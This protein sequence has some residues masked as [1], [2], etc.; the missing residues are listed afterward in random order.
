[1]KPATDP[2]LFD[3]PRKNGVLNR[4][5]PEDQPVHDWYRFVLSFPPHLVREYLEKFGV[6][7][8]SM[9]L[10]PFCG[11]GTT[12]VECKK[13]GIPVIGVEALPMP[14]F[15][16]SVKVDWSPDPEGLIH[17]AK[18]ISQKALDLLAKDGIEDEPTPKNGKASPYLRTLPPD[19]HRLLL[20]NSISPLPLHKTLVL[21]EAIRLNGNNRYFQHELLALAK[22]LVTSIG[23]VEFGPEVGVGKVKA[24]ASVVG[25]WLRRVSEMAQDLTVLSGKGR[26]EAKVYRGDSRKLDLLLDEDSVDAVFTSP[27]YPNE[28]DYTRTTRLETILLGFVRSRDDLRA[29]KQDLIRSNTRNVYKAD[30]DDVWIAEHPEIEKIAA[31]IEQ[32]RLD[33]GKTSG[34]ERLY[35]R[36][37]KLYFGGMAQHLA[38]LRKVL[39][40]GAKLGYVVGDQASYLRVMIRT[41]QLL[42]SIAESLGYEVESIDLFRTRLATATREQLREEVLVL[43]WPGV[44]KART[45]LRREGTPIYGELVHGKK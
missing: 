33:L 31:A 11:T 3:I 9:V 15:A 8:N 16:C 26:N 17:H 39:K 10:D 19:V 34:F 23:N 28:K 44:R 1:M 27:P 2:L 5:S 38:G 30:S 32:R 37:A 4:L 6:D 36:V 22:A 29:L 13:R 14:F 21:L 45:R 40:P 41:G 43:R 42:A 18:R 7:H 12:V 25:A 20:T 35:H 24:D